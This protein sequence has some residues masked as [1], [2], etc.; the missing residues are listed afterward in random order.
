MSRA[1]VIGL[2]TAVVSAAL[3]G[4]APLVQAR[5]ARREEE[6]SGLGLA[7]LARLVLRPLWLIGLAVEAGSFLLEVYALSV[8]PV[9]MVAPVMALDMIVFT[10]LAQRVLGENISLTGWLGVVAMVG[11]IG[12]LA[13][14]FTRRA[15]V[16]SSASTDVL[17]AFLVL[18]LV[19]ALLCASLANLAAVREMVAG[20]AFG[21]GAAAGVSYAIATLATR[22]IGLAVNE[23]REGQSTLVDLLTTPTPY[24][25]VLFS[26]LA[27]GLQQRGLQG[28]AAVIAFPVTSG[29]SAFLPVTLGLTLF[30]EPAPDGVRRAAFIVAM[31]LV[32]A[33]I[34]ALGRDR[35]AA[36][37]SVDELESV[38]RPTPDDRGLGD[39]VAPL[40]GRPEV[41]EPSEAEPGQPARARDEAASNART[42]TV[43]HRSGMS[44]NL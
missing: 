3:Y 41:V 22:Q 1:L 12:L 21:F 14:A 26:V 20:A 17:L 38:L 15:E 27:L 42:G 10:L 5:A 2:P 23:R 8:A 44:K 24:V 19:F 29:V 16:G 25:L 30:S 43:A 18:G 6:S 35:M 11:G 28:R 37:R 33:G 31:V 9:A 36:D 40:D 13:F 34:A 39:G 7:L 4:I 32:A